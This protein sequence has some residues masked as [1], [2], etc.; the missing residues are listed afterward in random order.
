MKLFYLYFVIIFAFFSQFVSLPGIVSAECAISATLKLGLRGSE[1][2]C[3]QSKLG[4]I[5]D[6]IFGPKTLDKVK[7]FQA[8]NSL[9]VDGIVGLKTRTIINKDVLATVYKDGCAS[10]VG[11]STTTGKR[12]DSSSEAYQPQVSIKDTSKNTTK[13]VAEDSN[14]N[15]VGLDEFIE[16][17]IKIAKDQG[18]TD[19]KIEDM[20]KA[21]RDTALNSGIDFR[22]EFEKELDKQNNLSITPAPQNIFSRILSKAFVA[23]GLTTPVAE[24]QSGVPF[25]G[26]VLFP[27]PCIC[28]VGV[29]SFVIQIQPLPPS[30]ATSLFYI[31]GTQQFAYRNLPASR[32]VLGTYAPTPGICLVGILPG[33][34]TIPNTGIISPLT[35]SSL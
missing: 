32:Y 15:L 8:N 1:V 5:A 28:N 3:L 31:A 10:L 24:A 29:P 26:A 19:K 14:P 27:L 23:L 34:T 33:C 12:C 13:E 35:G 11:Y 16:T 21:I 18:Y 20:V 7:I 9:I 2:Q 4:I 6:G 22:K 17:E 30:F 25:G